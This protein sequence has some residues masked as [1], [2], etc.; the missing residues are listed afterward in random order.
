MPFTNNRVDFRNN[1]SYDEI[2]HSSAM[3]KGLVSNV[4]QGLELNGNVLNAGTFVNGGCFGQLGNKTE[5]LTLTLTSFTGWITIKTT[6]NNVNSESVVTLE[7]TKKTNDTYSTTNIKY[8][9]IYKIEN[10]V[11]KQ[12]LRFSD[13]KVTSVLNSFNNQNNTLTTKISQNNGENDLTSSVPINITGVQADNGIQTF[14]SIGFQ[15]ELWQT[16]NVQEITKE[17]FTKMSVGILQDYVNGGTLQHY[18]DVINSELFFNSSYFN[19]TIEKFSANTGQFAQGYLII[20]SQKLD[21]FK[22]F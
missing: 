11:L 19:I 21:N 16:Q 20:K 9:P 6:L 2:Q 5:T 18:E 3:S 22:T 8:F 10:G 14:S 4:T 7:T 1:I 17:I 15:P 12:D 13:T